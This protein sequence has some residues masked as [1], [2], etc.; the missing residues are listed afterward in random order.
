MAELDALRRSHAAIEDLGARLFAI[1]PQKPEIS[2]KLRE[3]RKLPFEI[4]QDPGLEVAD[5]YGLRHELP[6]DLAALYGQF[7][8]VLSEVNLDGQWTLPLPARYAIDGAGK[9]VYSRVHADYKKRPEPDETVDA[10]RALG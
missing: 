5:A 8:I 3:E 7:G 6:E 4:L 9:V 2:A 10:V 1:S